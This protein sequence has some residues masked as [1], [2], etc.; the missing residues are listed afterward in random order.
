MD[1]CRIEQKIFTSQ[2]R[3]CPRTKWEEWEGV[4]EST[5]EQTLHIPFGR[6]YDNMGILDGTNT[7]RF[8]FGDDDLGDAVINVVSPCLDQSQASSRCS[9]ARVQTVQSF[10]RGRPRG[11][12]R[13]NCLFGLR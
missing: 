9:V 11:F 6:P 1:T 3:Q 10:G 7:A 4:K 8:L 2:N 5:R 13:T 12:H